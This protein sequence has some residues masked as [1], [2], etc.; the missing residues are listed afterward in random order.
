M[1][2]KK[3]STNNISMAQNTTWHVSLNKRNQRRTTH[4]FKQHANSIIDNDDTSHII[5]PLDSSINGH[6][7]KLTNTWIVWTHSNNDFNWNIDSYKQIYVINSLSTFWKFFNNLKNIDLISYQYYIMKDNSFPT[8]EDESNRFGG[9]CSIRLHKDK[10]LE[11]L[12]QLSIFIFNESF[13]NLPDDI[14]GISIG[15]KIN[16]G[17]IK[18]WNKTSTNDISNDIPNYMISRYESTP[19]YSFN[20]STN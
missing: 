16:W 20:V 13:T 3:I 2:Q 8:W 4:H 17:L 10:M 19:R 14:N 18:I 1:Q 5:D 12:E 9:T 15:V 11:L 7:N 6:D